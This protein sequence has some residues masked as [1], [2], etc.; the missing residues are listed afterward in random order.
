MRN[1]RFLVLA[2][3][4]GGWGCTDPDPLYCDTTA[5]CESGQVC[6]VAGAKGPG[7]TCIPDHVDVPP[8]GGTVEDGMVDAVPAECSAEMPCDVASMAP[9]C[10]EGAG[11]CRGC[12]SNEDCA[13]LS[14]APGGLCDEGGACVACVVGPENEGCD[15][16]SM[17]P[18]CGDDNTCRGCLE[19]SECASDVCGDNGAC[20]ADSA[21]IYVDGA[22]GADAGACPQDTP[23]K[24]IAY[25][26]TKVTS[27]KSTI[28]IAAGT[29]SAAD[30]LSIT[31]DVTLI[32]AGADPTDVN[33]YV[34]PV[35]KDVI[36]VE[37]A[38]VTID[39]IHITGAHGDP[40]L[41]D[42]ID[43][44]ADPTASLTI[45]RSLVD[46]NDGLGLRS[47]SCN[48]TANQSTVAAN[49]GGGI[50]VDGG[51]YEIVNNLVFANGNGITST[52]G[53]L[54]LSS[55]ETTNVIANN[56]IHE[57]LANGNAGGVVCFAAATGRGNIVYGNDNDQLSDNCAFTYSDIDGAAD[58]DKHN[59]SADPQFVD[60]DNIDLE[61]RDYHLKPTSPCIDAADPATAPTTDMDGDPR[62]DGAPDIGA[63]EAAS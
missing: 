32:G 62:D 19:N 53:G 10:D 13:G 14:G 51:T 2:V 49:D 45:T 25:A 50:K 12:T 23:C 27:G 22:K 28:H 46:S 61:K 59:I 17:A 55:N 56:T 26:L 34:V 38:A 1:F 36:R 40:S 63:D 37:D 41:A 57:N 20:I 58:K 47:D 15:G 21:I 24:T 4:V 33:V 54:F 48:I 18:I 9:F 11:M 43:C 7:H 44:R 29:Y 39:N 8:D 16:A 52:F 35:D 6:D 60:G 30:T 3:C 31:K 42:G 5:D